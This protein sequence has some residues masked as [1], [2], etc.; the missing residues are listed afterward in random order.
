MIFLSKEDTGLMDNKML[1]FINQYYI[2]SK[3]NEIAMERI[4][5]DAAATRLA[6]EQKNEDIANDAVDKYTLEL[7]EGGLLG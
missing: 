1:A 4:K 6:A 7:I 3:R 5:Y 2:D